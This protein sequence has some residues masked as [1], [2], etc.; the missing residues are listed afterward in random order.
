VERRLFDRGCSVAVVERP[1]AETL[2]ALEQAGVLVLLVSD[3]APDWSLPAD[4]AEA[5][6]F[7]ITTL[8]ETE[9]LLRKE[10]LTG[11][12]GI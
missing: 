11:G 4:D 2:G 9:I 6:I 7:V 1:S 3:K 12:E 5:A 8:E 10:L